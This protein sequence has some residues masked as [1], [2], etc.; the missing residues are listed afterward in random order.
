MLLFT[1]ENL[2]FLVG[3]LIFSTIPV[4][5]LLEPLL[6]ISR[7]GLWEPIRIIYKGLNWLG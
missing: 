5:K 6:M 4:E 1:W 3:R 7:I 2:F